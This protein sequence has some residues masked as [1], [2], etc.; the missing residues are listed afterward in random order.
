MQWIKDNILIE[1]EVFEYKDKKKETWLFW[2][3]KLSLSQ[4]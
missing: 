4:W 1:W 3:V 2:A